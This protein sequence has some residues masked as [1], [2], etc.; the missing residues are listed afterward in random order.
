MPWQRHSEV[1]EEYIHF[2]KSLVAIQSFYVQPCLQMLVQLFAARKC[3][4]LL[5]LQQV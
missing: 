3:P 1:A 4:S 2:M 5:A